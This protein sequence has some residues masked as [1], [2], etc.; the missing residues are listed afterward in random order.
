MYEG[1]YNLSRRP[2]KLTPDRSFLF[3]SKGH[4]RALSYLLYGLEQREGFV[5]ITGDIGMGKTLLI[6]TLFE[7][8]A[9]RPIATARIAAA[10]LDAESVL[11][12]VAAAFGRPFEGSGKTSLLRDLE[13]TLLQEPDYRDGAVLVVDEAQSFTREA[14]EE[15]RIL[16]NFEVGGRALIQVFLVGQTELRRIASAPDMEQLRQRVIASYHLEP[17]DQDET[18]AYITHRMETAGWAR[19]PELDDAVYTEVYKWSGGVPRRVNMIMDRLL[20][21]GYLEE[22]HRLGV[23]ELATVIDE[24]AL[25]VGAVQPE[26]PVDRQPEADAQQTPA[27]EGLEQR[28]TKVERIQRFLLRHWF[29]QKSPQEQETDENGVPRREK[30]GR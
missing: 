12:L 24:M 14:L 4:K 10:N 19:D 16:S 9:S 27:L 20:L 8:L 17:L 13:Q 7:E 5:V 30:G 1:F 29:L 3:P 18:T 15:L 2:F 26:A 22:R 25:E 11:P 28:M 6:Q 21:Y 23:A